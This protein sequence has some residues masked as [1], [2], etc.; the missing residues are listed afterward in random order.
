MDRIK[1]VL[2]RLGAKEREIIKKILAEI[3]AGQFEHL[4]IKKLKE[5]KDVFRA[6]KGD[7]RIIFRKYENEIFILAI[8]RRNESAYKKF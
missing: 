2:T 6:R 8:E 7:L 4:D 5:R 1:K 3:A